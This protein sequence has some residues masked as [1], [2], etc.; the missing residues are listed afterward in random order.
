M[1][2][3]EATGEP[4]E[5]AKAA[6]GSG[7]LLLTLRP[8]YRAP[9]H[10]LRVVGA[11]GRMMVRAG[12]LILLFVAY[13]LWGTGLQTTRAQDALEREF[14]TQQE[15]LGVLPVEPSSDTTLPT[16]TTAPVVAPSDLPPPERGAPVGF[17]S[18]PQI[19]AD[20]YI[21]EGVE[22]RWLQEGPG[23]FPST[24]M[25][26]QAGNAALAGHRT[27][28]KAPFNRV[29][30]LRPGDQ[31]FVQTLQGSFTYEVL[32]QPSEDGGE[33]K[34]YYV[35]G[36][37]AMEIL[38][39]KG[40]NRLTLMAC[41]PKYSARQRIVVEAKLVGNPA[42]P[43]APSTEPETTEDLAGGNADA[44]VPAI[45]F[46]L[47]TMAVWFAAWFVAHRARRWKW[48][49]YLIALP[50]FVVLLFLAFDSINQLLPAAY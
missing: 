19:G 26:G 35:V 48:P 37:T 15:Q 2:Q 11:I 10:V 14:K 6:I 12:V 1:G 27:T 17:I 16:P 5:P 42:P 34:G 20:F 39:D 8:L 40:D 41:H 36:P 30:E 7:R 18:I 3:E 23:H 31:V 50:F 46:S 38:S 29:D 13:Q 24:P 22:L 9:V 21:V 44:R 32:P 43:T 28:W 47:A 25:P 33:P 4:Y 49:A 45:L